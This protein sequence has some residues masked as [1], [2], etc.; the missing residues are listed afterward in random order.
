MPVEETIISP[1][2]QQLIE[3]VI[4]I[5]TTSL[6]GW[7]IVKYIHKIKK[8]VDDLEKRYNENPIIRAI[9][10]IRAQQDD[11]LEKKFIEQSADIV[12]MFADKKQEREDAKDE[13]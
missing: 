7:G 13:K 10:K 1:A 5:T 12:G 11:E 9:E 8:R 3:I 6:I 4:A 2:N